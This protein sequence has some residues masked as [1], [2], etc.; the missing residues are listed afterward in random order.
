MLY[1]FAQA[2]AGVASTYLITGKTKEQAYCA[3]LTLD[4]HLEG[5][6]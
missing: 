5:K 3:K 2:H 6:G 4:G 1:D